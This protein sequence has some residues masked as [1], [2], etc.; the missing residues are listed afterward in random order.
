MQSLM[1]VD[2]QLTCGSG[3]RSC[4][5][6]EPLSRAVSSSNRPGSN[7]HYI[8]HTAGQGSNVTRQNQSR[9]WS[10]PRKK[11]SSECS[12]W[13]KGEKKEKSRQYAQRERCSQLDEYATV[14]YLLPDCLAYST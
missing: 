14:P 12:R 3:D 9:D 10:Y 11:H 4:V 6:I 5:R 1:S 2:K 8:K 13:A 7:G